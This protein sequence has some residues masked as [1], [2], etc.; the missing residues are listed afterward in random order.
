MCLQ[1]STTPELCARWISVGS[2]Y[3]FTRSHSTHDAI[4]Q[5][6]YRWP[7]VARAARN[8]LS[9]RYQLLPHLY[10]ALARTHACG[11]TVMRP[12]WWTTAASPG[13]HHGDSQPP[14]GRTHSAQQ[15]AG[16]VGGDSMISLCGVPGRGGDGKNGAEHT[17]LRVS[18]MA[19]ELDQWLWGDSVMMTPVVHE[20][21]RARDVQVR[22][23]MRPD[24]RALAECWTV[25]WTG[26]HHSRCLP[27]FPYQER[28]A[29]FPKD[30]SIS[31]A[32][33]GD[34][35]AVKGR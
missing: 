3:T 14:A 20:G 21:M 22:G 33:W 29:V 24:T 34:R 6:L 5:E 8:A 1:E 26:A 9:L 19:G 32:L 10:S 16:G 25:K 13:S 15:S 11:G 31:H 35:A 12:T 7:E 27:A 18:E 28:V 23:R 17:P 30:S 4:P 2:F